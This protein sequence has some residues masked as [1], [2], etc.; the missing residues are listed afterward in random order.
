MKM[1][2][3]FIAIKVPIS[4]QTAEFIEDIKDELTNE[5]IRWVDTQ[6]LHLTLYFLGD[7]KENLIEEI[8]DKLE[9]QLKGF[10]E[11]NIIC[12]GVGLFRNIHNPKVL[13]LGINNSTELNELKNQVN[14]V[15]EELRY[16]KEERNFKPHLTLGRMKYIKKKDTLQDVL[17]QYENADIQEFKIDEVIFYE[18]ELT[19][20]GA[21][22]KVLRK[23]AL[24]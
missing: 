9:F 12:K 19:P 22:Y 4:E 2:R 11:F 20:G 13:W 5:K 10:K 7:T 17:S 15:V 8:G 23:I 3:T 6:N 24:R 14:N 1:K 16:P 18:S 21:I